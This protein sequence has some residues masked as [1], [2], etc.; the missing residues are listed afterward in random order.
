MRGSL[1]W[2][3]P[4]SI[5]MA[6]EVVRGESW[7]APLRADSPAMG[8][9]QK[10]PSDPGYEWGVSAHLEPQETMPWSTL[11]TRHSGT[12]GSRYLKLQPWVFRP[13]HPPLAEGMVETGPL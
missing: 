1:G 10:R 2:C 5:L 4:T 7:A 13:I 8:N 3:V 11:P 6:I 12:L 9:I